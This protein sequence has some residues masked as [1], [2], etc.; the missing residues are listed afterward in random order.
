[1]NTVEKYRQAAMDLFGANRTEAERYIVAPE[2]DTGEWA[3]DA[4]AIIYLEPDMRFP[5]DTGCIPDRLGYY[6][7]NGFDNCI[8]LG[9][10]AGVG[11]VEYFNAAVAAVWPA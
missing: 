4:L 11:F 7:R 5:E 1:M 3:P 10:R 9:E 6:S 8:R 2:D